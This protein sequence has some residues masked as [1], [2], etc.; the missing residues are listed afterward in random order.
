[1]M[2]RLFAAIVMATT[3]VMELGRR[4]K[5]QLREEIDDCDKA[6]KFVHD[7]G[8]TSSNLLNLSRSITKRQTYMIQELI[9]GSADALKK[10]TNDG[11]RLKHMIVV[12]RTYRSF[13]AH[14]SDVMLNEPVSPKGANGTGTAETDVAVLPA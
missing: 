13:L 4:E 12:L 7:G 3:A 9:R 2:G 11:D 8:L 5:H 10:S 14:V 6:L 1:M